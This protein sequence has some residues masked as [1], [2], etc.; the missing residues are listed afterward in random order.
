MQKFDRLVWADGIS[1]SSFGVRIGVRASSVQSFRRLPELFPPGWTGSSQPRVQRLYSVIAAEPEKRG[2]RRGTLLYGDLE[3]LARSRDLDAVLE[4]FQA[5]L[6]RFVAEWA[7]R[8]Y[9]VH[10]GVVGWKGRAILVPGRSFSGKSTLVSELVRAGAEY[11]SDEYAVFDDRGRVHPF[12]RA[13]A[14]RIEG[15]A[16]QTKH[17]PE[18]LGGAVGK[19]PLR[20]GLVLVSRYRSGARWRPRRLTPG[21]GLLALLGNSVSARRDPRRVL[22]SLRLG[23]EHAIG[24][25]GVRGEASDLVPTILEYLERPD[26]TRIS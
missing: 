12:P 23:V 14:L 26:T 20:P 7:P 1:F 18:S 8:K 11:Y 6:H 25:R 5:D 19:K 15:Q 24:W 16:N 17:A 22:E 4:A 3:L 13:L 10:A 21:Q 2:G 9:F